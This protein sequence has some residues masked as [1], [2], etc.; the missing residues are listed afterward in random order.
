[1]WFEPLNEL[2]IRSVNQMLTDGSFQ[3]H[4]LVCSPQ[5]L[6]L[7]TNI[8][9]L[10]PADMNSSVVRLAGKSVMFNNEVAIFEYH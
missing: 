9:F 10:R 8:F 2:V 5:S 7:M 1:M 4:Y 6:N 3:I